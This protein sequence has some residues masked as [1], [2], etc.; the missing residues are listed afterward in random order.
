MELRV[1]GFVYLVLYLKELVKQ[2]GCFVGNGRMDTINP[3]MLKCSIESH[4]MTKH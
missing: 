3:Q 4:T 1:T 2:E